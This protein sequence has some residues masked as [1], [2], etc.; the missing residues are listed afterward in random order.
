MSYIGIGGMTIRGEG[1][2][3]QENKAQALERLKKIEGQIQ[4]LEKMIRDNRYCVE[5]LTQISS[6]HEALRGV[7]KVIMQ[8]YLETCATTALRSKSKKKA[9]QIYQ[10][11]MEIIYKFA[12]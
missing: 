5:I 3:I 1:K 4:G 2:M 6:V 7:G 11:L 10:E 12:K 8:N 9:K